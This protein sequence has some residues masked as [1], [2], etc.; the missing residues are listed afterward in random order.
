MSYKA[1][2]VRTER[3]SNRS[4]SSAT[5]AC[6]GSERAT[7]PSLV[8]FRQ[9][10]QEG[11]ILWIVAAH[12]EHNPAVEGHA[13]NVLTNP[14]RVISKFQ[15]V[16]PILRIESRRPIHDAIYQCLERVDCPEPK[17]T[18][19]AT[20]VLNNVDSVVGHFWEEELKAPQLVFRVVAAIIDDDVERANGVRYRIQKS[21]IALVAD[22]YFATPAFEL[23]AI[24]INIHSI[25]NCM[26]KELLPHSDRAVSLNSNF[27][28]TFYVEAN[29]AKMH[30]VVHEIIVHALR[31]KVLCA[32]LL[33]EI[34]SL[35]GKGVWALR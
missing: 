15:Q 25:N 18:H 32:K 24:G 2:V 19:A 31:G 28:D 12:Y 33:E 7:V 4:V 10:R 17:V 8:G 9:S 14:T 6:R 23:F 1:C 34:V 35:Y 21:S 13:H 26:R 27:E 29:I 5:L 3:G 20:R 22:E 30:P 16:L 11:I